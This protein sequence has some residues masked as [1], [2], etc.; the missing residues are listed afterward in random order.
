MMIEILL[1]LICETMIRYDKEIMIGGVNGEG[2]SGA[3]T[4]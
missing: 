1:L 2:F 4:G 3:C